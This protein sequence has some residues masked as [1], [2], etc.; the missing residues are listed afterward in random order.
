MR[1]VVSFA[2]SLYRVALPREALQKEPPP[3]PRISPRTLYRVR[4]LFFSPATHDHS[5]VFTFSLYT[6]YTC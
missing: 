6:V 2:R 5:T 3:H 1:R 4:G